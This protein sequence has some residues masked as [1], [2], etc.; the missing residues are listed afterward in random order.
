LQAAAEPIHRPSHHGV[1]LPLGGIPAEGIGYRRQTHFT[2]RLVEASSGRNLWV[3]KGQV[4]AGGL[5]F[6]GDGASAF[7]SASAIFDDLQ[8]K[9]VI[10]VAGS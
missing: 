6:V 10:T 4:N 8:N 3:G 9:G 1:E 2:A 5:L 7:S